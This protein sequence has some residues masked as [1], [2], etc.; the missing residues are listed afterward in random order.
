MSFAMIACI[1]EGCPFWIS[2]HVDDCCTGLSTRAS[3]EIVYHALPGVEKKPMYGDTP[4]LNEL[5]QTKCVFDR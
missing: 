5:V 3:I 2:V 4:K 1:S